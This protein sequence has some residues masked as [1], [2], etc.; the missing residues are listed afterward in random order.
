MMTSSLKVFGGECAGN[1]LNDLRIFDLMTSTWKQK[2]YAGEQPTARK[3]TLV[4]ETL[5]ADMLT[6]HGGCM[7]GSTFVVFGGGKEAAGKESLL[8]FFFTL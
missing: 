3:G 8:F 7:F 1:P 6:G 4:I 5:E 2:S